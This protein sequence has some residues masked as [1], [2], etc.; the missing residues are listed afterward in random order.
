MS[1][2]RAFLIWIAVRAGNRFRLALPIPLFLL[3]GVTDFLED[4]ALFIPAT[5]TEKSEKKLSSGSAKQLV[6]ACADLLR[7]LALHS[8]PIDLV[9]IDVSEG[10]KRFAFQ[11]K[12]R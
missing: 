10:E 12:L 3:L 6:L 2:R 11:F 5:Y 1:N 7:E 4:A 8:E 9:D